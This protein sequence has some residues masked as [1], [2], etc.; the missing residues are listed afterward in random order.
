MSALFLRGIAF[1]TPSFVLQFFTHILLRA[2]LVW[3][4]GCSRPWQAALVDEREDRECLLDDAA[5]QRGLG[6]AAQTR[7][8]SEPT[9]IPNIIGT[10]QEQLIDR[11]STRLNSSHLGISYAVF[12]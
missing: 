1:I 8:P 3:Q 2:L 5:A 11:K 4:A 7:E 10:R 12:C 9:H 6:G